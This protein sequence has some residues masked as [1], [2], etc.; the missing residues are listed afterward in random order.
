MSNKLFSNRIQTTFILLAAVLYVLAGCNSTKHVGDNQYLLRRN[1]IILKSDRPIQNK[2]EVKDNLSKLDAQK[3]NSYFLRRMPT[4]LWLYNARYKKLHDRPDS[5]LPKSVERPV[6]FDSTLIA[7]SS[8]NMKTYLFNQGYF[9]AKIK[10]TFTLRNK[11]AY[12]T[13]TI[14]AGTNFL[15]RKVNYD[16]DDSNIARII[17]DATLPSGLQ[18]NKEFTYS[19]LEDE[20]SRI[21]SI[22][23]NNGYYR[24]SQENV[25]FKLDTFD[26]TFFK[27]AE[28]PFE[29][30]VNFISSARANKKPTLDIEVIIRPADDPAVYTKYTIASV[31]VYPDYISTNTKDTALQHLI[32]DVITIDSIQFKYHTDYVHAHVL[33]QHLYL[34]PGD[35][36]S[37]ENYDKTIVKL[38]EL[39]IFQY[40][41]VQFHENAQNHNTLDC[42]I[43]MSRTRRYDLTP[44][45]EA[46]SGSTY[47]LG[48]SANVNFRDKNFKKGADLLTIG[49]NGG[50]ELAYNKGNDFIKDFS[51]LT[52]YYGANASIDFPKFI[53]PVSA[54]LFD[55]SSLPHTIIGAGENA[56]DRV[57]YF[58]LVNTSA[59]F[60]YSWKQNQ[61]I[62]WTLSPAFI[63]II[64]LPVETD[65]FKKVLDSNAYLRNSYKENFIE[66]EN[67]SFTY[68][69]L[70]KK[71]GRNYSF[72]KL[73]LEEAGGLLGVVNQLG[74]ALND[75]YKIQYAQYT[76]FDFDARHYVTLPYSTFAF[77][78]SGG[79]GVPYGQSDALPYIKQYFAGGPY[80]MRGWRIRTLGPGS[81]YNAAEVNNVNQIDRTGD[82]K[83]ELNG[84]Y[85]F[86]ITPLFANAVKLNGALFADAGNIW[87]A[88]KDPS[89]PGGEFELNTLGQDIAADIGVG[90]RFD[91]ASFLT[92]RIDV[93]IPVKDPT[94]PTNNGWLFNAINPA[95]ATWRANNIIPQ[96]SIGYPF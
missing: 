90:L 21:V 7:R 95:N 47:S 93:A 44:N 22:V 26:K 27:D 19:M 56:I 91:I 61:T 40:I 4:K 89:Y 5:L 16:A 68:D 12:V 32:T 8:Q 58:T 49:V 17:R 83:L 11:K 60:T 75:L 6:I 64:R 82:I 13:H 50:V 29:S 10:D 38:N 78:F 79:I 74:V 31:N 72:L 92:F 14:S 71:H 62:T 1:T 94:V 35:I 57:N 48:S 67:I 70:L 51:L 39:G 63:N 86:P 37:Q 96:L 18:S 81:Y 30:A 73:S 23:R 36:Y 69:D 65:S 55:N 3:P 53:A 34:H 59:N 66:G 41:K 76:K 77:R 43:F 2:G 42:D 45:L 25:T 28:S 15:I 85:R 52:K 9:Y 20:R 87:L 46:S 84:E 24:F 54:S 33:Y 80:S 88:H